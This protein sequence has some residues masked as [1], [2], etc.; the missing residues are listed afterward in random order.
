MGDSPGAEQRRQSDPEA[1]A[2]GRN[3]ISLNA[4]IGLAGLALA[5]A[6]ILVT[7][8]IAQCWLGLGSCPPS[9][10][11]IR[12]DA[13]SSLFNAVG[14]DDPADEYVCL[15]N[16]SDERVDMTGWQLREGN[17]N[18]VNTLPSFALLPGARV[19]IH[20]GEGRDTRSDLYGT[21]GG[22]VW[23]NSGD[24]V[25]LVDAEGTEIAAISYGEQEK[26]L[27]RGRCE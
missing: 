27:A 26:E 1:S 21:S 11:D 19:R 25:T 20:P 24:S 9:L 10:P 23:T 4:K 8:A 5:V 14:Y 16:A 6:A 13:A 3:G 18:L 17:G 7:L 22:P 2:E 12:I 15:A